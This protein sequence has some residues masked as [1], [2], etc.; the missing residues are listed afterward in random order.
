MINKVD[1]GIL[2]LQTDG[3]EMYQR[4]VRTI[5]NANITISTYECDDMPTQTVDPTEGT[6][7]FGAALFGWGFTLGKFARFY[8]DKFK[9]DKNVLIKKLWGDNYYDPQLKKWTTEEIAA[10]GTTKLKRGFVEFIMDPI[11]KLMKKIMEGNKEAVYKIIEKLGVTITNEEKEQE[12]KDLMK[13]IF[14][15]W[16]NAAEALLEMVVTKLPSPVTAQKYR[17]PY[18][19]EGPMDDPCA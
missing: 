7:A 19:Y 4:F 11:I 17:T 14:M 10:D 6:V 1:R 3:E 18:L 15:K 16:L 9:I 13:T 5:E 8:A 12:G 2:E